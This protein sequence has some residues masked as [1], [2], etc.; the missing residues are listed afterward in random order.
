MDRYGYVECQGCGY[1]KAFITFVLQ[2]WDTL[3]ALW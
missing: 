2:Y 3:T 1:A